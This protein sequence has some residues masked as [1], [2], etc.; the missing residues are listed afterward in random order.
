MALDVGKTCLYNASALGKPVAKP[1]QF[2]ELP[3]PAAAQVQISRQSVKAIRGAIVSMEGMPATGA[4]L[5][6]R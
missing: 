1:G 2:R 4:G 3:M 6:A 5:E